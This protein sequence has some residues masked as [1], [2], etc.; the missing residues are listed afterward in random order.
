MATFQKRGITCNIIDISYVLQVHRLGVRVGNHSGGWAVW[1]ANARNGKPGC[2]M[3]A[4][5]YLH[6]NIGSEGGQNTAV[7]VKVFSV[8]E[9]LR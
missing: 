4:C 1:V 7:K 6:S 8:V 5:N 2:E 3:Q 9:S